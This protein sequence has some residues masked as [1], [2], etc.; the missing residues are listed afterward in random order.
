MSLWGL[1]SVLRSPAVTTPMECVHIEYHDPKLTQCLRTECAS[2]TG[3]LHLDAADTYGRGF[4]EKKKEPLETTHATIDR[5]M[6]YTVPDGD[7]PY[8]PRPERR[9]LPPP[10]TQDSRG[11]TSPL[12]PFNSDDAACDTLLE[13]AGLTFYFLFLPNHPVSTV[14]GCAMHMSNRRDFACVTTHSLQMARLLRRRTW[15]R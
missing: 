1:A 7:S 13:R 8:P 5:L 9:P 15:G 10:C 12:Q 3:G 2:Y 4:V 14:C 6:R 11:A